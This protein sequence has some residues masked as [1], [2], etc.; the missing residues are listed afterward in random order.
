MHDESKLPK[1][2][3]A[4]LSDLRGKLERMERAHAV[5]HGRDWYAIGAHSPEEFTLFRLTANHASAVCTVGKGAVLL[6]GYDAKK[7]GAK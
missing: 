3:Q 1:W 4:E 7:G 6:V 5:L 2:A